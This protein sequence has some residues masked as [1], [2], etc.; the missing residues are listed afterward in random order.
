MPT[1]QDFDERR[2]SALAYWRYAHDYLRAARTLSTRHRL[3][4][5]DAQANYHL[6][7]QALEFALNAFMR[8]SGV[9]A[10]TIERE[11]RH[12]LERSLATAVARGLPEPPLQVRSAVAD[13]AP[14]HRHDRCVHV[15]REPEGFPD[16]APVFDAICWT[17]ATIIPDVAT[18]YTAHFS[19]ESSPSTEV[20]IKRLRADLSAPS[21]SADVALA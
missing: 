17:L 19:G 16:L 9:P 4:C 11:S 6:A 10:A 8:A 18:D 15:L 20:F 12:A 1:Q 7:A 2:R 21:T 3:A 13:I 5:A 14:H